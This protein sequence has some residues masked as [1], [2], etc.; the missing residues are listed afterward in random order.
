MRSTSTA[1]D[2]GLNPL[3]TPLSAP[4][5]SK[6]KSTGYLKMLERLREQLSRS[7]W[8][9]PLFSQDTSFH[10]SSSRATFSGPFDARYQLL[11]IT[12]GALESSEEDFNLNRKA[13]DLARAALLFL[14]EKN[15]PPP[16]I[17]TTGP[18][19]FALQW[20]VQDDLRIL[21]VKGNLVRALEIGPASEVKRR[22]KPKEVTASSDFLSIMKMG[23][24]PKESQA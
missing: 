16:Q 2:D 23:D 9:A 4:Y 21:V 17:L 6:D 11:M 18:D 10:R 14:N 12:V 20:N 5:A 19:A 3:E 8:H 15:F 22:G 1:V 13:S 7:A 24:E